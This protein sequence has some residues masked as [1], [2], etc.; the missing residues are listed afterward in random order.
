MYLYCNGTIPSKVAKKQSCE[1]SLLFII[2]LVELQ[3]A[4][5]KPVVYNTTAC[6]LSLNGMLQV[7]LVN[8]RLLNIIQ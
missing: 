8:L 3:K 6:N 2:K 5:I 1:A 7:Q 4:A